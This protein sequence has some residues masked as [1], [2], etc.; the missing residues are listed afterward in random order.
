MNIVVLNREQVKASL[1]MAEV[2]R[3]VEAAYRMKAAGGT[4]VWPLV[5]HEFHALQAVTDIR[6]GFVGGEVG[7]H[8][9]KMLNNFPQNAAKGLPVFNGMLMLFDS[10][11]GLPLGV[12]DA[13]YITSMRTGAAGALGVKALARPDCATLT[14]LGAGKQA[15]YQLAATLLLMPGITTVYVAD[16]LFIDNARTLAFAMPERLKEEF[17]IQDRGYVRFLP[18]EDLA[19]AVGESDAIITITPARKPVIRREWVKPGTHF[20]CI[21]ADMEGKEEIDP[22]LFIGARVFADDRAQCARV[23]EMELPIK[24]GVI[25]EKDV[26]GELGEVL[27]GTLPGRT[28]GEQTTIFDATGLALLDIVTA[29]A[30]IEGA[31]RQNIGLFAEM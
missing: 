29:K 1:T 17:H 2:I 8:G 10:N 23:G 26:A 24:M 19:G 5:A 7:L 4:G 20:S 28:D 11:T 15:P 6:S 31:M 3:G 13:S 25:S 16:P 9:L 30:A 18:V 22:A 27:G 12:M 21:G 14:I